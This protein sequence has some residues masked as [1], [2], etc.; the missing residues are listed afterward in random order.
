[1]RGGIGF[2][3]LLLSFCLHGVLSISPPE[4]TKPHSGLSDLGSDPTAERLIAWIQAH[5]GQVRTAFAWLQL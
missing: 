5:G 3:W 1:M 4:V 2:A